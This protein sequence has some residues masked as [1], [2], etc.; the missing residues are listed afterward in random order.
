MTVLYSRGQ[1]SGLSISQPQVLVRYLQAELQKISLALT[2]VD[3]RLS[4]LES[5]HENGEKD[6]G[7]P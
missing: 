2:K 7:N 3:E 5:L 4:S 6:A 1:P